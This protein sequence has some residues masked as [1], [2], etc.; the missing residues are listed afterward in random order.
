MYIVTSPTSCANFMRSLL[1]ATEG[2]LGGNPQ[3]DFYHVAQTFLGDPAWSSH[4]LTAAPLAPRLW[5]QSPTT[6][7][8]RVHFSQGR[9]ED[10]AALVL[11]ESQTQL[12]LTQNNERLPNEEAVAYTRFV[13]DRVEPRVGLLR[14]FVL[15]AETTSLQQALE[16]FVV[17][18]RDATAMGKDLEA[19]GLVSPESHP[20]QI[21]PPTLKDQ[22]TWA[23][24]DA[25]EYL[26]D[27]GK[28]QNRVE[29]PLAR[30]FAR[31][32]PNRLP[33]RV[34]YDL[35]RL[36]EMKAEF[37]E[38]TD[39]FLKDAYMRTLEQRVLSQ[40]LL[41]AMSGG[42]PDD[43]PPFLIEGAGVELTGIL[44][45]AAYTHAL[46]AGRVHAAPHYRSAGLVKGL[47]E[48]QGYD[49]FVHDSIRQALNRVTD[50][51][52]QG[53]DMGTHFDYPDH[54]IYRTLSPL[55][56]NIGFA[57]GG[58]L[59][60]KIF[61]N[62]G[63]TSESHVFYAE[64]G[65]A[66]LST[67]EFQ[68]FLEGASVRDLP[69]VLTVLDNRVGISVRPE[70]GNGTRDLE[71]LAKA[72]GFHFL[73][74]D[75]NDVLSVY[76]V[77]R[78]A[79]E[80][81]RNGGHV[82]VWTQNLPRLNDHSS[83]SGRSYRLNEIDPLL[84]FAEAL[85]SRKILAPDEALRRVENPA[86]DNFFQSH[87]LGRL[88]QELKQSVDQAFRTVAAE[89]I[90]SRED[91]TTFARAEI[92]E[93]PEP[94]PGQGQTQIPYNV[95]TRAALRQILSARQAGLWGQ[96][97]AEPKGGVF[98][99]KDGLSHEIPTQVFNGPI[100][101]QLLS[102]MM[103]GLAMQEG[104]VGIFE[105]QFD[106]YALNIL[107][108]LEQIAL[109]S[110]LSA[111]KRQPNVIMRTA[112]EPVPSGAIYHSHSNV[113][114]FASLPGSAILVSASTTWDQHGLLLSA[115]QTPGLKIFL[116]PKILYRESI[117]PAFPG[118]P[119]LNKEEASAMRN[120]GWTP[121]LPA[122]PIPLGKAA[123]RRSFDDIPRDMLGL[124]I[125]TWGNGT[126]TSL[127][128]AEDLETGGVATEVIDL[129]TL[130]PW[131][132]EAVLSSVY[133]TGTLLVA[134]D[135]PT[136]AGLAEHIVTGVMQA[137]QDEDLSFGATL[138]RDLRFG[139]IGWDERVPAMPQRPA[140]NAALSLN[141]ARIAAK[142]RA[143]AGRD[144]MPSGF[145]VTPDGRIVRT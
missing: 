47:L 98:Q 111:G 81:V 145:R 96:G 101:E 69:V 64:I 46:G 109:M 60:H 5:T 28:I 88:G 127:K 34:S 20:N 136:Q 135:G 50:P 21:L 139:V 85:V 129:R 108:R 137:F 91:A 141:A 49:D 78:R 40:K 26:F 19:L 16:S 116:E 131:D 94:Q 79:A 123:V 86:S 133:K 44:T 76:A 41:G 33:R 72:K 67:N 17:A 29:G 138:G 113:N 1:Q 122:I 63:D 23:A 84:H 15:S 55:A 102:A 97:I 107:H 140:V 115:A 114:F 37:P 100:N 77:H 119:T 25:A 9:E 65:D 68:E 18:F 22:I 93:I 53:R 54:G 130:M 11:S 92:L 8:P 90:A 61:G 70:D 120:R 128:A 132:K 95:G 106:D 38:L 52:S 12:F 3:R 24:V 99:A 14:R 51:R 126:R 31:M 66:S 27:L 134:H 30:H 74:M 4:P 124:T 75:G 2:S 71:A 80:I 58:A 73:T 42:E 142:A 45:A 83:S 10:P 105:I 103:A 56:M 104:A 13:T 43:R 48:A 7:L 39:D 89:P 110:W 125:V 35:A 82:L 112:T 118:E 87:H 59:H 32:D 6:Q 117:G 36:E 143:V 144:K 57:L 62:R 121:D